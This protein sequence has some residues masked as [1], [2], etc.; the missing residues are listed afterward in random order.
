MAK[1]NPA[2][3]LLKIEALEAEVPALKKNGADSAAF[4]DWLVRATKA[5]EQALGAGS[6]IVAE[7]KG[8][9]F[10]ADPRAVDEIG[11]GLKR[12]AIALPRSDNVLELERPKPDVGRI[13]AKRFDRALSEAM[14]MLLQAKLQLRA[15]GK[16]P[17]KT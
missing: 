15:Q 1:R 13:Q 5:L 7:F 2:A 8:I 6:D 14:E 16:K 17:K 11:K 3:A 12:V 9:R 4:R 10:R